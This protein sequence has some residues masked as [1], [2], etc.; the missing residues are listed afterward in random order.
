MDD[1]AN[2]IARIQQD[3]VGFAAS[4]SDAVVRA[5]VRVMEGE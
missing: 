1:I 2:R 3:A 4:L 5:A